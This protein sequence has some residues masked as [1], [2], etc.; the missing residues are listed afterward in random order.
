M[1][2]LRDRNPIVFLLYSYCLWVRHI[3]FDMMGVKP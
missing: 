3:Y 2:R 1:D